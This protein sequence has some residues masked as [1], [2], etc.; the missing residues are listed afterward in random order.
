MHSVA[1]GDPKLGIRVYKDVFPIDLNII[2]TINEAVTLNDNKSIPLEWRQAMVGDQQIYL[3]YRDCFDLK[4]S[5]N[6]VNILPDQYNN[7]KDMFFILKD[8]L[9]ECIKDYQRQ[10]NIEMNYME[11]INFVKYGEGQHFQIHSDHGFSYV[12]AISSVVYLND[13]YEGGELYFNNFDIK[14]KPERGDIVLFP[15]SF[16]YSHASLPVSSGVKYSAVT[17]FDYND[18]CHKPILQTSPRKIQKR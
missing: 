12:C 10:Y 1:V 8:K 17:M 7:F 5:E 18:R 15:S 11:A 9:D 13:E 6:Q 2:D 14:F 16:I 3:D 4:I